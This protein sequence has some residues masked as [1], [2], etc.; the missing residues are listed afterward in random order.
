MEELLNNL[1][2]IATSD[3]NVSISEIDF[4]RSISK[5]FKFSEKDFQRIFNQI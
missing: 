3:G 2:Y 1:F 4:L 5:S